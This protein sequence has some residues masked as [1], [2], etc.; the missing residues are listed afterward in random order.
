MEAPDFVW[1]P[2]RDLLQRAVSIADM[3]RIWLPNHRELAPHIERAGGLAS[4]ILATV[5]REWRRRTDRFVAHNAP[6]SEAFETEVEG[7]R[8]HIEHAEQLLVSAATNTAQSRYLRGVAWGALGIAVVSV[9]GGITLYEFDLAATTAI[10]L[11]AG[12]LGAVISVLQ[13]LTSGT[14]DID[15]RAPKNRLWIFGFVRPW[16]GGVLG[17]VV[18]AALQSG[19][20]GL[21]T[22]EPSGTGPQLAYFGIIGFLAGFNERFAQDVVSRSSRSTLRAP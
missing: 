1:V 8:R 15:F 4:Q 17:M 6:P 5:G 7:L 11:P 12:A 22:Q 21:Q 2:A 10:A 3:A 20:L 14:L 19:L 18:Y 9:L 16:I 13:R